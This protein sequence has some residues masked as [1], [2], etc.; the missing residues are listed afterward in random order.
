[1]GVVPSHIGA[2]NGSV[3]GEGGA[4]AYAGTGT[5]RAAVAVMRSAAMTAAMGESRR[6]TDACDDV[7]C[8]TIDFLPDEVSRVAR[9][10]MN[11]DLHRKRGPNRRR[12]TRQTTCP[13][14]WPAEGVG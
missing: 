14:N 7:R 4:S 5:P 3:T 1:S 12:I 2:W 11:Q 13:S 9:A 8:M 10:W 6:R